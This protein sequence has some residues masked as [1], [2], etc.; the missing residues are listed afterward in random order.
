MR[1][2]ARVAD[3]PGASRNSPE[4]LYED[5][6]ASATAMITTPMCT[7][8]PPFARPTIPRH[9][10]RRVAST[11]WR[12]AE[13]AANP[14][15]PNARS[16]ARPWAPNATAM[17]TTPV[18]IHAGHTRRWRRSSPDAFRHGSTGATAMRNSR[19]MPIGIVMRSKYG[20][21]IEMRSPFTASSTRGN[22]VPRSTTK[23]NTANSTLFARNAPSR[24]IGESI[25]PV[26][27]VDRRASRSSPLSRARRCAKNVRIAGPI[28]LSVNACTESS[29]PERVRNVPRIVS[30]NVA[31]SSERFQTRN[32]PRRSCTITECRYAVPV[33]HGRNDAFSTGSHAQ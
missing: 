18:P 10:C 27:A 4:W 7:I 21:P 17:T 20:R 6:A 29:T 13:P 31:Q 25:D 14:P 15:R 19:A 5:E 33:S 12:P 28:W 3:S 2:P 26:S 9:P 30:E 11:I 32:M 1:W 8:I 24:E 16:G 23:A 22:T